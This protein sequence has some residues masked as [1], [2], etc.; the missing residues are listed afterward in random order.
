[1]PICNSL[2]ELAGKFAGYW[3]GDDAF[4]DEV[5]VG[6]LAAVWIGRLVFQLAEFL[7]SLLLNV[8]ECLQQAPVEFVFL[9]FP[10]VGSGSDGSH[11]AD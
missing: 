8:N 6:L 10:R 11:T 2:E 3:V 4:D 9:D 1:M 5:T 7:G